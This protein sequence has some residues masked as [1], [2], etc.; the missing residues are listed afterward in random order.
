MKNGKHEISRIGKYI[1][2]HLLYE[3][4]CNCLKNKIKLYI[5]ACE[6]IQDV[7]LGENNKSQNNTTFFNH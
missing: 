4:L 6:D 3:T 1:M 2:L 5:T 7:L